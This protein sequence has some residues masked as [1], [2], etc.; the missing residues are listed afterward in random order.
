MKKQI[1]FHPIS[2]LTGTRDRTHGRSRWHRIYPTPHVTQVSLTN[3]HELENQITCELTK[4][5]KEEMSHRSTL[6]LPWLTILRGALSRTIHLC[7]QPIFCRCLHKRYGFV[8]AHIWFLE[9]ILIVIQLCKLDV[10]SPPY[11]YDCTLYLLQWGDFC[12][13]YCKRQNDYQLVI[14]AF[15]IWCPKE[16]IFNVT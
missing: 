1:T 16:T 14:M 2:K 13:A 7:K 15:I 8:L 9:I 3:A 4:L 6:L 12:H 5:R 11:S 10:T